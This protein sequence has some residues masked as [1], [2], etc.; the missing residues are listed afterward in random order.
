MTQSTETSHAPAAFQEEQGRFF[1]LSIDLLCIAGF[2]GYFKLVSPSWEATLGW[3]VDEMLSRPFEE[4]LHPD[5]RQPT[6]DTYAVQMAEGR[7]VIEFENRYRCKDGSYRRLLWNART[8]AER[9]L[10]YAIARDN[11]DAR[12]ADEELAQKALA[13]ARSNAELEDFTH[14]VSHDLKEPLRGIEA[15]SGF[16]AEEYRAHLDGP[17]RGYLDIIQQSAVRMRDLIDDLLELS[18]IGR[19]R[20]ALAPVDT[21]TLLTDLK[22]AFRFTLENSGVELTL[23]PDMPVV[24][25]DAVR[26]RQV[27]EN[28]IG[29]AIKYNGRES[30]G[31][32]KV[33]AETREDETVFGVSDNGPGISPNYREKIFGIFQRLVR[34]DEYEGT[35]VGLT[36]CKK[37]VEGRGGRIWVESEGKGKGSAFFFTV[38]DRLSPS[39]EEEPTDD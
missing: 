39:A 32:I 29:N 9:E 12:R 27:F 4:F 37:I 5:D 1:S 30:G 25:G 24:V 36:I 13:L 17:A 19:T 16:L 3:S 31:W 8:V 28:L 10:I 21:G 7:D 35:G 20:P 11:T 15:F 34:R 38:P 22:T 2:D 14:V 26:L 23:Q 33:T 6:A 18:R